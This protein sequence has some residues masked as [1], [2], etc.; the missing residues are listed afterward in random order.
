MK[1]KKLSAITKKHIKRTQSEDQLIQTMHPRNV[2]GKRM[3][4]WRI[5]EGGISSFRD[6]TEAQARRLSQALSVKLKLK[7]K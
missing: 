7:R 4:R 2:G 3:G 1:K 6:M 5:I